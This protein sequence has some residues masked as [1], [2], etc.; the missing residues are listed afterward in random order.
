[1]RP[2]LV[3][4]IL[5]LPCWLAAQTPSVAGVVTGVDGQA[6][7]GATVYW[8]ET[9]IGTYTDAA[10]EF[11]LPRPDTG[12]FH[13]VALVTGYQA[14]TLCNE[15][16]S[17]LSIVL[18]P[19][20]LADVEIRDA[21]G[22]HIGLDPHKTEIINRIELE[23]S[24]CC[25]LAGCFNTQASAE[26][27]TTNVVT[28]AKELQ[29]LG[30]AGVYNQ[31]LWEGIP[32]FRGAS[33]TY[34]LSGVPGPVL[35]KIYIAKGTGSVLQGF[36]ATTGQ[37]NVIG[38]DPRKAEPLLLNAY[39]NS[40]LEHQYNANAAL[41]VG[42]W[43]TLLS[44]HMS[45]PG[46]AMDRDQDG[47]R[48]MPWMQRY[49]FLNKW[50]L[51]DEDSLG[52]SG[53]V[54]G[55]F[56]QERRIGGQFQV[57]GAL[58]GPA[59]IQDIGYVQPELSTKLNFRENE[60]NKTSLYAAAQL[61][62]Q[63]SNFGATDYT[64]QQQLYY[65]NL[66]H[67]TIWRER[68]QL[69][70]GLSYRQLDLR[71]DIA[72]GPLSPPKTFA[73]RYTTAERIPGIYAENTAFFFDERLTL[74]TGLRADLHSQYGP[75]VTP[76]GLL[77]WSPGSGFNARVSAGT[78]YRSVLLFTENINLLA[79]GRD[80]VFEEELQPERA[81][82][83]GLNLDKSF[84]LTDA[85]G[86]IGLDLYRTQF[87]NQFFPDYDRDPGMAYIR[88]FTGQSVG[89]GLQLETGWTI[90]E[91]FEFRFAYNY[92]DVTRSIGSE[93]KDLPFISRHKITGTLS[94]WTKNR[95]FRIDANAHWYGPQRL[96]NTENHPGGL[97]LPSASQAY[98][99]LNG[100]VSFQPDPKGVFDLYGG[101]ENLLD[102]RQLRPIADWQNP[103]SSYF[104]PSFA[105]GPTRGIEAYL[106]VRVR[107]FGGKDWRRR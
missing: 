101:V 2:L 52:W 94:T 55:R 14:D 93:R 103:F 32:L 48:D 68:Q 105:W 76:R 27:R 98:F 79:S 86:R 41:R 49:H 38:L 73:G 99:L 25:D 107:P 74:I 33:Y 83:I 77:R 22:T 67:S 106:G 9:G 7:P 92:L 26:A 65:A 104:D 88:N 15:G 42:R 17:G 31:L 28:N 46:R 56:L 71:E 21:E 24:A 81:W 82:N 78:A 12:H 20:Q 5:L 30:L 3:C 58:G 11:N 50:Q 87:Q 10:G 72:F 39:V 57:G 59:Y 60:K 19:I 85:K 100:Q 96:P 84:E 89:M 13:L 6:L 90:W 80:V 44:G 54:T 66:E 35:D 47:F 97:V 102:F 51:R 61:H 91:R 63:Q 8:M 45:Q 62:Q 16:E 18:S 64:A 4:L 43:H 70:V 75:F 34:S 53:V 1:M 23:R 40:F 29:V 36:E 95:R 69:R 37:I